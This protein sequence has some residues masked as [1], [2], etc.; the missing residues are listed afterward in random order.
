MA[1]GFGVQT[2]G[3]IIRDNLGR[4]RGGFSKTAIKDLRKVA[5]IYSRELRGEL[6]AQNAVWTGETFDSLGK[7]KKEAKGYSIQIPTY[8]FWHN[9]GYTVTPHT[10]GPET[11]G[12][13]SLDKWL[14]SRLGFVPRYITVKPKRWI[15]PGLA[16]AKPLARHHFENSKLDRLIESGGKVS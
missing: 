16:R 13:E 1:L 2:N 15:E 12:R 5:K 8:A 3:V 6:L 14:Q 11:E 10:I 7:I 9:F 4:I